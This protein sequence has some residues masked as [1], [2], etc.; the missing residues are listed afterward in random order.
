MYLSEARTG[1]TRPRDERT[2]GRRPLRVVTGNVLAI[3]MVSLLTDVSSEMVTAI[4]PL[5]LVFGLGM[6]TVQFGVLDGVYT[7]ATAVLRLAGGHVADR[8][9]RRKAV[10]GAGYALSA[11]TKLGFLLAGRSAPLL[12]LVIGVDRAGKGLRTA[13]RDAIISL[14]APYEAQGRAFGVHRALDTAGALAGPLVA[15]GVLELALG[16]YDAVFVTSFCV[17]VLGVLV[18]V[19]F[20]RE[21]DGVAR[22][23]ARVSL[24]QATALL[25]PG[26]FR[27]VL[28]AVVPLSLTTISDAF[29]YLL[30]LERLDV[31]AR[32]LPLLPVVVS[33]PYLLAAVPAGRLAD[34]L[35]RPKVV[36]G[37]YGALLACY[38]L[39]L[40]A[41]HP[42]VSVAVLL[43]RGLGYAATDGVVSALV[44]PLLP[45]RRRATGLA[46]VQTGQALA[47][48]AASWI[49][50][51]LWSWLGPRAA[52][53]VMAAGL[54]IT[55]VAAFLVLPRNGGT[56]EE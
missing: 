15:F 29:L 38:L 32:W 50:G 2:S 9:R 19:L 47:A 7:G 8:F 43:L 6:S 28:L 5:Y 23:R 21:P 39:V 22:G 16:S 20:V 25:G 41:D 1:D 49:F 42:V 4:L 30:V 13:P 45:E 40:A 48:M 52:V 51:V 27:R 34:R 17:A 35:G 54:A 56:G 24:A 36:L 44:G 33:A 31:A 53:G 3:G 26:P 12:G 37:G 10:A 55:L 14:S 11:V 46:V 18:L